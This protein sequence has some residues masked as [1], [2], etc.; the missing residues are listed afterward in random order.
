VN[1]C[2]KAARRARERGRKTTLLYEGSK[3]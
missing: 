1:E 3:L 2:G